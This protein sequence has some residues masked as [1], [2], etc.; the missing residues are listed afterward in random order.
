[1]VGKWFSLPEISV[2]TWWRKKQHICG[3]SSGNFSL[4]ENVYGAVRNFKYRTNFNN[5]IKRLLYFRIYNGARGTK[6]RK[7]KSLEKL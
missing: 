5:E 2:F 3:D 1:M 7:T 6:R 4:D